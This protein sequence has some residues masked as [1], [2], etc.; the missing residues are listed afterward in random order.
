VFNYQL[1]VGSV[2]IKPYL[3]IK[4]LFYIFTLVCQCML[5]WLR[6]E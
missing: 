1:G 4:N 5:T 2:C 3:N 6:K